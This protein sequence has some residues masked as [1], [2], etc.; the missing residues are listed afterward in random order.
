MIPE[1]LE[2]IKD[3][4]KRILALPGNHHDIYKA[5]EHARVMIREKEEV[6]MS[7]DLHDHEH[8]MKTLHWFADVIVRGLVEEV[9]KNTVEDLENHYEKKLKHYPDGVE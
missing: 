2:Q 4:E 7:S 1:I 5:I 9:L 8:D 3:L 6:A